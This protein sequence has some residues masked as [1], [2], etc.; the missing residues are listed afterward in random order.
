VFCERCKQPIRP[1]EPIL[2][3]MACKRD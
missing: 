3:H 1:D 2:D